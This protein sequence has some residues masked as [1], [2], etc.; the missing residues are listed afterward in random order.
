[1]R[2]LNSDRPRLKTGRSFRSIYTRPW[3]TVPQAKGP[4]GR[5]KSC[6]ASIRRQ[7]CV[8]DRKRKL[9]GR[10]PGFQ[11][12]GP[13]GEREWMVRKRRHKLG[14]PENQ[15]GDGLDLDI[16][17]GSRLLRSGCSPAQALRIGSGSVPRTSR[18]SYTRQRSDEPR[19]SLAPATNPRIRKGA[20]SGAESHAAP[21]SAPRCG[22]ARR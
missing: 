3:T 13:S 6:C 12:H 1:M 19:Q 21:E 14:A 15:A 8:I 22:W 20:D 5:R 11:G 18:L 16:T 17:L 7:T 2:T 9:S 10:S 4:V